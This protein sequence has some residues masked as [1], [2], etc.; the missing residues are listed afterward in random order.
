MFVNIA[1][2]KM[3]K[4][5]AGTF[6]PTKTNAVFIRMWNREFATPVNYENKSLNYFELNI[7]GLDAR[8]GNNIFFFHIHIM[9]L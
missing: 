3:F 7:K 5:C 9:K 2:K 1:T 8:K 4:C 6:C